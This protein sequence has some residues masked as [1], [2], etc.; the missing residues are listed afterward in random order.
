MS[1][2]MDDFWRLSVLSLAMFIG[3]YLAGSIPLALNLSEV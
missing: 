1:R 3:C 2:R